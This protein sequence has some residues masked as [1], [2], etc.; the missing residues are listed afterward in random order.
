MRVSHLL[1]VFTSVLLGAQTPKT[2]P[3]T[4]G[5]LKIEILQGEGAVN[6]TKS[7]TNR[8]IIVQV[9]DE[10]NRPVGGA[11]VSFALPAHGAGGTFLNGSKT[12]TLLTDSKGQVIVQAFKPNPMAGSFQIS[13]HASYQG[14]MTS[15][16]ITQTNTATAGA[17]AGGAA[18]AGISAKVIA[19]VVAVAAAGATG[20]AVA[21]TRGG[22]SP[23]PPA[24]KSVSVGAPVFGPPR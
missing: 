5:Q 18:G 13:V 1:V 6:Y 12:L 10:N 15:A 11:A 3:E 21:V 24:A 2:A 7:R 14:H 8:E 4:A 22:G 23:P 19:V 16:A 20:A 17:A 9:H